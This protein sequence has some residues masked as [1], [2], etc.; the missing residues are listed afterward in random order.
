MSDMYEPP[1][2]FRGESHCGSMEEYR[3]LYKQSVDDPHAFWSDIASGFHWKTFPTK[4]NF[5]SYNFNVKDGPIKIE[6]MKDGKLNICYNT[7]DRHLEKRSE[8]I[9]FY[10][11]GNDPKD[12]GKITYQELHKEV[13][14]FANVLRAKGVKKGD[15]VAI[16]M[17]MVTELVVAMLACARIG[18]VHSI[19]FGGY[20]A[21]S[22]AMRILD[23][24][25]AVLITAD[26][27][28]R[29][30]KLINLLEV[31]DEAM[32]SCKKQG[33]EVKV[34]IVVCHLPRLTD[35]SALTAE[36]EERLAKTW[37][38]DR[39]FWWHDVMKDAAEECE[40]EWMNAE[41]PLFMLYTSGSTGKPKGVLHTTAGY[42]LYAA[43]TFKYSFDYQESDIY[44]CTADIG[45]ITGHTYVTYGP[46]LNGATSVLFEGTPFHPS[47]DRIFQIIEK[48]GVSKFYTAPTAIRAL[49]KFGEAFSTKYDMSKLK[50]LGTVGEPINPEAWH[51][52]H[53]YVGHEKASI[54]DTYW[55]TETGGHIITPLPGCTPAKPGSACFPFFGIIPVILDAE[56]GKELEGEA[57]GYIAIKKPW[58]G[59]MR[60]VYGDHQRFEKTYFEKFPGYYM[61]G[62]GAK[63]D[64][65]GYIWI[66]GRI[67]DMLN[68]S[69]HLMSTS[70]V[71]SVL[72]EHPRVAEAAVVAA[73]HAIKGECLYCFVTPK[74]GLRIDDDACAELKKLVREK[75]APFAMP[76]FIQEAPNLPKT[77]SGKIMRRILRKI[78]QDDPE[79]GDISTLADSTVVDLLQEGHKALLL[80]AKK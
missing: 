28:W 12:E 80:A 25:A 73:P 50:V 79:I 45:W 61:S 27:T 9:A 39:D 43:T 64:K 34:N 21:D 24:K 30:K 54:V 78:A 77:R 75:I 29:G 55:Q 13:C 19:V 8:Q 49:M 60:T 5:L 72:V 46:M 37:D 68:C 17:P 33:H 2:F 36:Y 41:D 20:S 51:W 14:K 76:D 40:V 70:Q 38:A 26:G 42:M 67:D 69:G 63:R 16:Y 31:S 3:K 7:L 10:W 48:Y 35:N 57:E 65:D 56:S 4:D 44:W 74:D 15:R 47:T 71:E 23:A 6:W 22:L 18:A 66:T 62:D 53:K 59:I 11:E 32:E 58:P 52:Y 1:A